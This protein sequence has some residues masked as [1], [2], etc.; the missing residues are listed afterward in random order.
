MK[1]IKQIVNNPKKYQIAKGQTAP[2][3]DQE[4]SDSLDAMDLEELRAE[5][6]RVEIARKTWEQEVARG[7]FISIDEE[8]TQWAKSIE[9]I[10][11][12]ISQYVE[13][14]VYNV[15]AKECKRQLQQFDK[16]DASMVQADK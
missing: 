16:L 14:H 1:N 9:I 5:K 11:G 13:P 8:K 2:D 12:I 4:L 6:L 10:F 3:L 15:I 7:K